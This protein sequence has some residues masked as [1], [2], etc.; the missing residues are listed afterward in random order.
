ME[1]RPQL[2]LISWKEKL[3]FIEGRLVL[4]NSVMSNIV[5]YILSFFLLPKGV[6]NRLNF[7]DQDY[8]G[9]ATVKI[10]NIDWIS[11]VWSVPQK[12]IVGLVFTILK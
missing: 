2:C 5:L 11:E 7:S 3:L 8:F 12:T 6:L 4:I 9:R 10:R 1:E